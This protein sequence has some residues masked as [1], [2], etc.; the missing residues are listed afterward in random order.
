MKRIVL[1]SIGAVV[2]ALAVPAHAEE[3]DKR[4]IIRARAIRVTPTEETGPILPSFPTAHTAVTNSYAPEVDFTYMATRHIGAELIL[5]TTKH[6]IEGRGALDG[7]GKAGR[8][9]VLPPTLTLQ[10]HFAPNAHIRPYV[11][12]GVNYTIFY[13]EKASNALQ[14]AIG[15]TKLKLK[16]S[17]GYALQAGV[18]IDIT[19]RIFLNI[20][21]K[22]IDIDTTARLTTGS[23]INR[24]RVHL[25]PLV[26]GIGIGMRF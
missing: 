15:D 5:A 6:H 4:W 1:V 17:F 25:D 11:G 3:A 21:L 16:D 23:L 14:S 7:L 24:E 26:P 19:P 9:W 18:D 22:Y 12:A 20:D 10:Y 8:T 13:S 2:A